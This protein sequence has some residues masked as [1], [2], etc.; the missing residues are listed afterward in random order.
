MYLER[1]I[2]I[3]LRHTHTSQLLTLKE[4]WIL[5]RAKNNIREGLER[6]KGKGSFCNYIIISKR[7]FKTHCM[8][9]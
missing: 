7:R 2:C 8:G 5:K 3:F 6:G 9:V 1:Y 4:Q